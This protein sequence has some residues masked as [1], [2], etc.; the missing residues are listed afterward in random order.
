MK[1]LKQVLN[2]YLKIYPVQEGLNMSHLLAHWEELLGPYLAERM[3]PMTYIKGTLTCQVSSS[4]LIQELTFLRQDILAK[5]KLFEG[6]QKIQQLRFVANDEAFHSRVSQAHQQIKQIEQRQR[7]NLILTSNSVLSEAEQQQI[8]GDTDLILEPA[9]RL[10]AKQM[11][12]AMARRQHQLK[13]QSWK[14][15]VAC[16]TYYEPK[17]MSC[18]FCHQVKT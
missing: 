4:S 10:R 7:Q 18:P 11:I 5:L 6:G 12:L 3:L 15:C 2:H 13:Q 9:L 16:Q 8:S 1:S 17:F 14:I